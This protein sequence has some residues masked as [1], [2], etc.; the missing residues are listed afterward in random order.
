M[1]EIPNVVGG[2]IITDEWGNDIRDR[3]V[4]RYATVAARTAAH[5]SP[6]EGDLSYLQDSNT[7][8]VYN[9]TAWVP[10]DSSSEVDGSIEVAGPLWGVVG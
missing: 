9:G 5:P 3:T 8:D 1:A 2:E 10:V 6:I 4:Q 7:V